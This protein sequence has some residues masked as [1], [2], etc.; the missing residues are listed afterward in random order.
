VFLNCRLTGVGKSYLGRPWRP[1]AS[2]AFVR[3]EMGEQI[4]PE[5]WHNWGKAENEKTARFLEYKCTGPGADR[6]NRVWWSKELADQQ[7]A[8]L[9]RLGVLGGEDDW[10]A[11]AAAPWPTTK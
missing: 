4:R 7:T 1:D 8:K 2:V 11:D 10:H 5:G 6:S 3:C 9:T